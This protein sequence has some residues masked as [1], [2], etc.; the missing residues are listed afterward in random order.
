MTA[1]VRVMVFLVAWGLAE[2]VL[3]GDASEVVKR[4]QTSLLEVMKQGKQL[5][6]EGRYARLESVVRHTHDLPFVARLSL[7]KHWKDL[8]KEEQAK[9]VGVFSR[10]SIATYASRFD[11]YGGETFNLDSEQPLPRGSMRLVES[12]LIK[13][14]GEAVHFNYLLRSDGENWLIVN[15]VVDG[16]SDLALKQAEY[17]NLFEEEGFPALVAKLESQI[18]QYANGAE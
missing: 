10:L 11:G 14:D 18:R 4:L 2:P 13:A 8:S 3:G 6:Y 7:G 12:R 15:I 5:G 9:L 16:V 1:L 17:T